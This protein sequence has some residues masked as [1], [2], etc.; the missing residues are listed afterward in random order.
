MV[1][2]AYSDPP[3]QLQ[4]YKSGWVSTLSEK[5]LLPEDTRS[6]AK[7]YNPVLLHMLSDLS[8]PRRNCS[9]AVPCHSCKHF[10]VALP[11]PAV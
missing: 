3:A 8:G 6:T 11:G 9:P 1:E 2:L 7:K 5:A 10:R 4:K